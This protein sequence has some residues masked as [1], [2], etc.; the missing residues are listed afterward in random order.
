VMSLSMLRFWINKVYRQNKQT[1]P[2]WMSGTEP[3]VTAPLGM[4][5]FLLQ[6]H[7]V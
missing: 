3:T 5:V 7:N 2:F 4:F 6:S 1:F